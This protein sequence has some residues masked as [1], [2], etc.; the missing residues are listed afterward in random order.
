[1]QGYMPQF[2]EMNNQQMMDQ[3]GQDPNQMQQQMEMG[4]VDGQ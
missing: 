3:L 2:G 1:M 4:E